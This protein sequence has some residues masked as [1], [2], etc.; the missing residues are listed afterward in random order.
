[1]IRGRMNFGTIPIQF[2]VI[3]WMIGLRQRDGTNT[4][5]RTFDRCRDRA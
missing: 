3:A 1:M 2:V 4:E 5:N